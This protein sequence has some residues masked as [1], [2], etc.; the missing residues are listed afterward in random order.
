MGKSYIS[1]YILDRTRS[2]VSLMELVGNLTLMLPKLSQR[3]LSNGILLKSSMRPA[4]TRSPHRPCL[5]ALR[6]RIHQFPMILLLWKHLWERMMTMGMS[7]I[8]SL[9]LARSLSRHRILNLVLQLADS[10]KTLIVQRS[11]S[12]NTS[13]IPPRPLLLAIQSA[14]KL[15]MTL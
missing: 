4:K 15:A 1:S 8:S 10:I 5:F 11:F 3:K 2:A 13:K 14:D 7:F 12:F 6:V 9:I